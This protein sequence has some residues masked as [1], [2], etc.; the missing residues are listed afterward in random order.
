MAARKPIPM[1]ELDR[2]R[3]RLELHPSEEVVVKQEVIEIPL[4][5]LVVAP[6]NARRYFDERQ[7]TELM[8]DIQQ[9]GLIHPLVVRPIGQKFEV[10]VGE[11]RFRAMQKANF[12]RVRCSV[13]QLTDVEARRMGL[14]ENLERTD[15]NAYEET[16]GWLDLLELNM[17]P[18]PGFQQFIRDKNTVQDTVISILRRYKHEMEKVR[19]NVTPNPLPYL[20]TADQLV[21]GTTLERVILETF[22]SER[23]NWKSFIENRLPLLL[24]PEDLLEHLRA[25]RLEYTK[26]K[27][28]GKIEDAGQRIEL[29]EEVLRLNLPLTQIRTRIKAL[30]SPALSPNKTQVIERRFQQLGKAVR[31][32]RRKLSKQHQSRLDEL[33]IELEGLLGVREK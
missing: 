17:S 28:L 23:M 4:E 33:L 32:G 27:E 12:A 2:F 9:N 30:L 7:L 25:G 1:G 6:W 11:R 21:I 24:L 31:E 29:S 10:V 26:A 5:H 19:H 18:E 15:L 13:R 3:E 22:S 8:I 20:Q 16:L 14:S